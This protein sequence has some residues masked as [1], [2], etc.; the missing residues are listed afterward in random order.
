VAEP[1]PWPN[2]DGL[3]IPKGFEV[4]S[5]THIGPYWGGQTTHM[6]H[7]GGSPPSIRPNGGG[8]T[9]FNL[10][11]SATLKPNGG[12]RTPPNGP[13]GGSGCHP[14]FFFLFSFFK[15]IKIRFRDILGRFS[16]TNPHASH[17]GLFMSKKIN[18][19]N[20]WPTMKMFRTW[21][22]YIANIF[23]FGKKKKKGETLG[24]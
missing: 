11:E 10:A 3:A 20:G 2:E 18:L 4:T 16:L 13:L 6:S 22:W 12:G 21:L 5:T 7:W 9:T 1:R 8:Q 15:K 14:I 19:S 17:M 24:G 23:H